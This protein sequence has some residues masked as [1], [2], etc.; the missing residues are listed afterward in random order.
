M[1]R[2]GN[3]GRKNKKNKSIIYDLMRDSKYAETLKLFTDLRSTLYLL[4]LI[5]FIDTLDVFAEG[6]ALLYRTHIFVLHRCE[7]Q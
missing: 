2:E 6:T 3:N 1:F 5:I 4:I 7:D